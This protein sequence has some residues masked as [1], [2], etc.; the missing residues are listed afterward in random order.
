MVPNRLKPSKCLAEYLSRSGLCNPSHTVCEKFLR[1]AACRLAIAE[2]ECDEEET[3][4]RITAGREVL[5]VAPPATME[6]VVFAGYLAA[7]V[8][9]ANKLP[10]ASVLSRAFAEDF[11]K[12]DDSW[13]TMSDWAYEFGWYIAAEALGDGV[14]WADDHDYHPTEVP[15]I[16]V[17]C[18]P[19][20]R[21][22]GELEDDDPP[23][24]GLDHIINTAKVSLYGAVR[25]HIEYE[26]HPDLTGY[27][28]IYD[29][30]GN[31]A[32]LVEVTTK[33]YDLLW[34]LDGAMMRD[35]LPGLDT[36]TE[37]RCGDFFWDELPH[38]E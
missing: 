34:T 36:R 37:V 17:S 22:Y 32:Q 1:G 9:V 11:P 38:V 8:S 30:K 5:D 19:G 10:L 3:F 21:T 2:W 18:N 4:G 16:D 26:R 24:N 25:S 29:D 12:N 27:Y 23:G 35:Q 13:I 7:Q 28:R 20:G 15:H 14:G 6:A 33:R 31:R